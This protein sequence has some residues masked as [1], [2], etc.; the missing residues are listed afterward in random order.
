[1]TEASQMQIFS[2]FSLWKITVLVQSSKFH[3]LTNTKKKQ[4]NKTLFIIWVPF[5]MHN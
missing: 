1:M 5:H 3:R 4:T 2:V